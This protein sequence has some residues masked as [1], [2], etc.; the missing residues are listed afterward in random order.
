VFRPAAA[1]I[2]Q[3][4]GGAEPA[5]AP[6]DRIDLRVLGRFFLQGRI[7][8]HFLGVPAG[9]ARLDTGEIALLSKIDAS[10]RFFGVKTKDRAGT[11]AITLPPE[12]VQH[13]ET[14]YQYLG[15]TRRPALQVQYV[16]HDGRTATAVLGC[17]SEVERAR[18]QAE[19]QRS[20]QAG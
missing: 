1:E 11:W 13:L 9:V 3:P 20:A 4:A 6:A 15:W 12:A 17:G 2:S 18:L 16:G 14:G 19:L 8:R 5:V 7:A 10:S